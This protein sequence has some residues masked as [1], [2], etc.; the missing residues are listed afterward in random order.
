MIIDEADGALL[1]LGVAIE[2]RC[3]V[4]LTATA[5]GDIDSIE[6]NYLIT[7]LGFRCYDSGIKADAALND[8]TPCDSFQQFLQQEMAAAKLI[9]VDVESQA[10]LIAEILNLE[11]CY[12]VNATDTA[13]LRQMEAGCV[14]VVTDSALMRGFDYRAADHRQGISLLVAKPL[15]CTRTLLQA[16]GRVGR[17]GQACRR[18]RLRGVGV[19][20]A[21]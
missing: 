8:P 21:K 14:F 4:G 10:G 19:D 9:Y 12:E 7:T 20:A 13:K 5:I 2:A 1:D 18:F 6:A 16:Y 15:S 11:L 3:V 17:Y